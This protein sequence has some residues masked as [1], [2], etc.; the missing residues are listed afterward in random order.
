M[1]N[2]PVMGQTNNKQALSKNPGANIDANQPHIQV[3]TC[4]VLI[5]NYRSTSFREGIVSHATI[6]YLN[7]ALS[8]S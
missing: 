2:G 8:W 7:L 3:C 6:F 5:I 1:N 4:Q